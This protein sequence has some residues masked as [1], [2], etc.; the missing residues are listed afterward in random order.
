MLL[1]SMELSL[2]IWVVGAVLVSAEQLKDVM[3]LSC[4]TASEG[5]GIVS[6]V[7]WGTMVAWAQSLAQEFPHNVSVATQKR[8]VLHC[9]VNPLRRN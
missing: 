6:A 3:E 8:Y 1:V 2:L 5:S 4:V 9:Y 7:A